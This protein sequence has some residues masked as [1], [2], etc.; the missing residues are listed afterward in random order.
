MKKTLLSI[1]LSVSL[2]LN[3]LLSLQSVRADTIQKIPIQLVKKSELGGEEYGNYIMNS[4][5]T[6]TSNN[7]E[8]LD[9]SK[10]IDKAYYQTELDGKPLKNLEWLDKN[11]GKISYILK[12]EP[13]LPNNIT[14]YYKTDEITPKAN[15]YF[16][17]GKA[18]VGFILMGETSERVDVVNENGVALVNEEVYVEDNKSEVEY[19]FLVQ[20]KAEMRDTKITVKIQEDGM[21]EKELPPSDNL[22]T[23][24]QI[25]LKYVVKVKKG[26]TYKFTVEGVENNDT[27]SFTLEQM[28]CTKHEK[29]DPKDWYSIKSGDSQPSIENVG[30]KFIDSSR[31]AIISELNYHTKD[32]IEAKFTLNTYYYNPGKASYIKNH[33]YNGLIDCIMVSDEFVQVPAPPMAYCHKVSEKDIHWQEMKEFIQSEK[34][35]AVTTHFTAGKLAG[36]TVTVKVTDIVVGNNSDSVNGVGLVYTVTMEKP[37]KEFIPINIR[38]RPMSQGYIAKAATKGIKDLEL[39]CNTSG[40]WSSFEETSIEGWQPWLEPDTPVHWISPLAK[41]IKGNI[42]NASPSYDMRN[43]KD[44]S[45][46]LKKEDTD[47]DGITTAEQKFKVHFS[48]EDG[49]VNPKVIYAHQELDTIENKPVSIQNS[50]S[51]EQIQSSG[52]IHEVSGMTVPRYGTEY[53][54][55]SDDKN[56]TNVFAGNL[57]SLLF[58]VELLELPV[59]LDQQNGTKTQQVGTMD[60]EARRTLQI[61]GVIPQRTGNYFTG[62]ELYKVNG[63]NEELLNSGKYYYPGQT[64]TLEDIGAVAVDGKKTMDK[65]VLKAVYGTENTNTSNRVVIRTILKKLDGSTELY[66]QKVFSAAKNTWVRV[67]DVTEKIQQDEEKQFK[68]SATDTIT[69]TK[70]KTASVTRTGDMATNNGFSL[71]GKVTVDEQVFEIYYVQEE[72]QKLELFN[73]GTNDKIS[74][75]TVVAGSNVKVVLTLKKADNMSETIQVKVPGKDELVTL[76]KKVGSDNGENVIYEADNILVTKAETG[77]VTISD[78]DKATIQD[79]EKITNPPLTIAAGKLSSVFSTI[80]VSPSAITVTGSSIGTVELKDG[81]GNPI[82]DANPIVKVDGQDLP[83]SS[84]ITNNGDGTYT[85]PYT[86]DSVG[87]KKFDLIDET[88]Q[89]L[90]IDMLVVESKAGTISIT[91]SGNPID[92]IDVHN[93]FTITVKVEDEGANPP[94]EIKVLVP[95]VEGEVV[96]KRGSDG[97]Y[98]GVAEVTNPAN[99]EITIV[100]EEYKNIIPKPIQIVAGDPESANSKITLKPGTVLIGNPITV[101]VELRDRFDNP[102]IGVTPNIT[103]TVNGVGMPMPN[104]GIKELGDGKYEFTYNPN[105]PG[106]HTIGVAVGKLPV[107]NK[108]LIVKDVDGEIIVTKNEQPSTDFLVQDKIDITFVLKDTEGVKPNEIRVLVP[109]VEGEVVL[110]KQP[111]GTYKGSVIPMK[112]ATGMIELKDS[113]YPNVKPVPVTISIGE[114]DKDQSGITMT[115]NLVQVGEVVNGKLVLKDKNGNPIADK[116]PVI[117]VDGEEIESETLESPQGQYS[118]TYTPKTEGEKLL[119]VIVDGKEALDYKIQVIRPSF[120][121]RGDHTMPFIDSIIDSEQEE[122]EE[123]ISDSILEEKNQVKKSN[124][125]NKEDSSKKNIENDKHHEKV[126]ETEQVMLKTNNGVKEFEKIPTGIKESKDERLSPYTEWYTNTLSLGNNTFL[127]ESGLATLEKLPKGTKISSIKGI[128]YNKL[129]IQR[130]IVKVVLPDGTSKYISVEVAVLSNTQAKRNGYQYGDIY[131]TGSVQGL[132]ETY[133]NTQN[134]T[135]PKTGDKTQFSIIIFSMVASIMILTIRKRFKNFGYNK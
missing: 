102:V 13:T 18:D 133:N 94:A 104:G 71:D 85:F 43:R 97:A 120:P 69:M 60:V 6:I 89:S 91:K 86:P 27:P 112:T 16:T 47:S 4:G 119:L 106:Y 30:N 7:I 111:D 28:E 1:V 14:L 53:N 39:Y 11:N 49:Y 128:Q 51:G 110:T 77:M 66:D 33:A 32:L 84:P 93:K 100:G 131:K 40:I 92:K 117:V 23:V 50:Y 74:N 130:G 3:P 122:K 129:G 38:T 108:T 42:H 134:L 70:V 52:N 59:E 107:I 116:H 21:A 55:E 98:V 5:T 96:L 68:F 29:S 88:D 26:S 10:Y 95:G 101:V 81:Y 109:G 118:F 90:S 99:G 126:D 58:Q 15:Y 2:V 37:P 105:K 83:V 82:K 48:V 12:G 46:S 56:K 24:T 34:N 115:P 79:V 9:N 75:D 54:S 62:Y 123:N 45:S 17:G 121:N 76:T 114:I 63:T 35:K 80:K 65:V 135:I 57:S 67:N 61:P 72:G 73:A 31:P 25:T 132:V 44:R 127:T 19:S 125:N 103:A 78:K 87:I 22:S 41:S 113:G 36:S 64:L 124:T 20:T 8:K